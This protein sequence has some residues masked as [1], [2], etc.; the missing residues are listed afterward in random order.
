MEFEY[1]KTNIF[2]LLLRDALYNDVSYHKLCWTLSTRVD[3]PWVGRMHLVE[4]ILTKISSY[5]HLIDLPVDLQSS[6]LIF[7]NFI[8]KLRKTVPIFKI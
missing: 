1:F 5:D 4:V 2:K 3:K 8:M 7:K 6:Y